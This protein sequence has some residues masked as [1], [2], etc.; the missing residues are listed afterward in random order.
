MVSLL[1]DHALHNCWL[2]FNNWTK[3]LE[4]G[5]S[6]DVLYF[7]FAKTFNSAPHNHLINKMQGYGVSGRLLAW[8]H[9]FLMGRKQKV[10]FNNCAS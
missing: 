1:I 10:V 2:L 4:D 3:P 6:V 8:L 7:D 9:D 5:Y